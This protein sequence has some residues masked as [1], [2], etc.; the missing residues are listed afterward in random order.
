MINV[1]LSGGGKFEKFI[2]KLEQF[3]LIRISKTFQQAEKDEAESH[4]WDNLKNN[5][6]EKSLGKNERQVSIEGN[7]KQVNRVAGNKPP[8]PILASTVAG[9][10]DK[11]TPT[12][13]IPLRTAKA[14]HWGEG[15]F[16]KGH[17]VLGITATNWWEKGFRVGVERSRLILKEIANQKI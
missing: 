12:H 3:P 11:G 2:A 6:K 9:F 13:F 10:L 7:L 1:E 16:S 8:K 15:M 5:I 4:N 17:D 14:L